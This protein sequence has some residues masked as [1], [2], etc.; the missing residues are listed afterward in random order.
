MTSTFPTRVRTRRQWVALAALVQHRGMQ[1]DTLAG[2]LGIGRN[3]VYGLVAE[4]TEQGLVHPLREIGVGAKWI[5]PTPTGHRW[6]GP[7][8]VP[9]PHTPLLWSIRARAV[10]QTRIALGAR[11]YEQ[12]RSD[13]D[14]C[15]DKSY[16]GRY[17]Y[18]GQ[19]NS[20]AALVAVKV[21]C[22][23]YRLTPGK[24]AENLR[25]VTTRV[26]TDGC[27]GL[28][29]VSHGVTPADLVRTALT[30]RLNRGAPSAFAVVDYTALTD[31]NTPVITPWGVA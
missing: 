30:D 1:I 24:L 7:H 5:I 17:P 2:F 6:Y 11:D 15:T 28:L 13:L 20:P 25:R 22:V 19:W 23:G 29:W 21:D 27:D 12:W 14:L 9:D 8:R 31:P 26:R 3:H 18:D 16:R 10:A 4:L